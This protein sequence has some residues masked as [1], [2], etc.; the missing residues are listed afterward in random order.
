[1]VL[2]VAHEARLLNPGSGALVPLAAFKPAVKLAATF[3]FAF[4]VSLLSKHSTAALACCMALLVAI[5][6]RLPYS[7]LLR[8]LVPIN[9]FFIFLWIFLPISFS[10]GT[11]S[12]SRSGLE[13]AALITL[14]SNAIA[15]MLLALLGTSSVSES[16]R[17]LLALRAPEKLVTLLLLTYTNLFR[18][19][20]EYERL[21][22]AAKL[23][24]FTPGKTLAGYKAI[25]YLAAML[26]VRSWQRSLR[27]H[28]AMR[29][30]GFSGRYPLLELPPAV[31]YSPYGVFF[32]LA[33]CLGA[34]TLLF[35][36]R[37]L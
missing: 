13:L 33:L 5:A 30:R 34:F 37:L 26:L 29:L 7:N 9:I 3:C 23:R 6:G 2:P 36:D 1:M 22:T 8:K 21:S 17:G 28:A 10:S 25:A 24:G 11:F 32:L 31:P 19:K 35:A 12:L 27:V 15:L 20:D 14:K 18:M 4:C 16:C